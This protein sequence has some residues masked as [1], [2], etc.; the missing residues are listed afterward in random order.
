MAEG[1]QHAIGIGILT[2]SGADM[3][4]SICERIEKI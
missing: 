2:M 1:K 4:V 3:Y